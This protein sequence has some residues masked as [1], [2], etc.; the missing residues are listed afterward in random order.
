MDEG[1]GFELDRGFHVM[2]EEGQYEQEGWW[3][4]TTE[5]VQ[6]GEDKETRFDLAE[7]FQLQKAE[8]SRCSCQRITQDQ[9][10]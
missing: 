1:V 3:S 9:T 7:E 4:E 8:E 6:P 10:T 5:K 2:D